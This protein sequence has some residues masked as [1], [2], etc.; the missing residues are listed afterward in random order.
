MRLTRLMKFEAFIVVA[1]IY[2]EQSVATLYLHP[3]FAKRCGFKEG[4]VVKV[5]RSGREVNF[6]V[7]LLDTAPE[8]GGIIPN[9]IFASYLTDFD[10]FKSFKADLELSNGNETTI[11]EIMTI[12]MEM[13]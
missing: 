5:S 13:K 3:D 12:I 7:K 9:S 6:R 8:N 4:D 10:N 1:R 11:A 2:S